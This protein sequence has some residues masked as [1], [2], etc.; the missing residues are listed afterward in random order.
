VFISRLFLLQPSP[1]IATF[2]ITTAALYTTRTSKHFSLPFPLKNITK[3]IVKAPYANDYALQLMKKL[4]IFT[5][6][7]VKIAI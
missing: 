4:A 3:F 7:G 6:F 2:P 5:T 1:L